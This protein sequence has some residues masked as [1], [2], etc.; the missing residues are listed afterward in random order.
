MPEIVARITIN[1]DRVLNFEFEA[2]N[3]FV[4]LGVLKPMFAAIVDS[5]SSV[6]MDGAVAY[7]ENAPNWHAEILHA[8]MSA[9]D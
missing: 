5:V 2:H 7:A 6:S 1:D 3:F 4:S 9:K 8:L